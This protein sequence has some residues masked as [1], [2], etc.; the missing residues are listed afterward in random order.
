MFL[1][2]ISCHAVLCMYEKQKDLWIM[3][4]IKYKLRL[5]NAKKTAFLNGLPLSLLSEIHWADSYTKK[6]VVVL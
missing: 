5:I 3:H 1:G 2:L 6:L 4:V